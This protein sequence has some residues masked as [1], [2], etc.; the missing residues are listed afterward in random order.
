MNPLGLDGFAFCEFTSPDPQAMAAQFEQL[1]FV[2]A[3]HRPERGLTLYRQGRIRLI[4]NAG[5]GR[6][7]AFRRLHGPSANGMGLR[8]ANANE[9][10]KLAVWR[11]GRPI[12]PAD[13]ALPDARALEGVGGSVLYLVDADP[14]AGWREIPGWREAE[15]LNAVGLDLLDHL[16]HNLRRGRMRTWADFYRKLF[17]FEEQKYFDIKGRTTGLFSQAMIA[18][19]GAI[20]I[21]LNESQDDKSQVEEFL[22]EYRGEGIQHLAL[23]TDDIYATVEQLRAR[24]VRL[25]DTIETYYE[26]V[27]ERIPGHGEDLERL[28]KNR[29]LI[30]GSLDEGVLLQIFTENL[31]GPHSAKGKPGLRRRQF[32]GAL[33]VHR[34]RP[35]PA[36]RDRSR[37][38]SRGLRTVRIHCRA[39]RRRK[40]R[41]WRI[42]RRSDARCP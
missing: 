32:P 34:A 40:A 3:A 7:A 30:D 29:I 41:R 12:D 21:P 24:A 2:A 4:L 42:R 18:P 26:L 1:G 25:Q 13:T 11:G 6:A 15:E 37:A 27:D 23:A 16:T 14:F 33:R 28:R 19:D 9:A 22:R 10:H 17:G 20:R 31:F 8:V 5:G 36:R 35:D 39:C 38:L